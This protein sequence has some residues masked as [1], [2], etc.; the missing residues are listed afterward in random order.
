LYDQNPANVKEL[1]ESQRKRRRDEEAARERNRLQAKQIKLRSEER[2][3]TEKIQEGDTGEAPVFSQDKL[4]DVEQENPYYESWGAVTTLAVNIS[5]GGLRIFTDKKFNMDELILLE[6]YVPSSQ[7]IVD[8]IARVVFTNYG[9]S[10]EVD[11]ASI[12]TAMQFVF[13]AESARSAINSHISSIQLKRIRHFKGFTDVE[14]TTENVSLPNKHYAYID[15]IGVSENADHQDQSEK[16][17]LKQ[18]LQ[19][20]LLVCI[21][22]LLCFYFYGYRISHPKNEIQELFEN[23]FKK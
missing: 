4:Q 3:R 20:L 13:I 9:N 22:G 8:I 14:P 10:T 2:A 11:A 7:R 12:S 15:S 6:A 16:P 1:W 21:I 18:V 19:G 17:L 5:G 23:S